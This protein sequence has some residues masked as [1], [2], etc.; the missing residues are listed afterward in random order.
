MNRNYPYDFDD[1]R[2]YE[3]LSLRAAGYFSSKPITNRQI[4]EDVAEA[5]TV[6]EIDYQLENM[7]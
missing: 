6:E 3:E 5:S 7:K 1:L 4:L 2:S